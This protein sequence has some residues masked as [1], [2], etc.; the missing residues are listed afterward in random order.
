MVCDCD[1]SEYPTELDSGQCEVYRVWDMCVCEEGPNT[2]ENKT[3]ANYMSQMWLIKWWREYFAKDNQCHVPVIP[4]APYYLFHIAKC[5][6]IR[7]PNK[8]IR[9]HWAIKD[10]G[11]HTCEWLWLGRLWV[12][13]HKM[14]ASQSWIHRIY[15]NWMDVRLRSF[16]LCGRSEG[17]ENDY[18]EQQNFSGHSANDGGWIYTENTLYIYLSLWIRSIK[19][20]A[21][22]WQKYTDP[23][24]NA[25]STDTEDKGKTLSLVALVDIA[26]RMRKS[27]NGNCV[28]STRIYHFKAIGT[29]KL[30][31]SCS[32]IHFN[33]MDIPMTQRILQTIHKLAS[34]VHRLGCD[35]VNRT[36]TKAFNT[37]ALFVFRLLLVWFLAPNKSV[38]QALHVRC[39][40]ATP[41]TYVR[42]CHSNSKN[43]L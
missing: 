15:A 31:N 25:Q 41:F 5:D 6:E 20:G 8:H 24:A 10:T 11:A 22:V 30:L 18:S 39:A 3:V 13:K 38:R 21:K 33:R 1:A 4:C 29:S 23:T 32:Q 43:A 19:L 7:V 35:T 40:S 9:R 42:F 16:S 26:Q 14:L 28:H 12:H 17:C 37:K 36:Q 2:V 34:T 27:A